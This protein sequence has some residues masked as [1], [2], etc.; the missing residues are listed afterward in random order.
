LGLSEVSLQ[1]GFCQ[2]GAQFAQDSLICGLLYNLHNA[3]DMGHCTKPVN[4]NITKGALS[5]QFGLPGS[6]PMAFQVT[7]R[8]SLSRTI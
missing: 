2:P 6:D 7:I 1:P 3:P 5:K 4:Q 8:N